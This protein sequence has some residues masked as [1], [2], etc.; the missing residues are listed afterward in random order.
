[1]R[2]GLGRIFVCSLL[3][4]GASVIAEDSSRE[5]VKFQT[6]DRCLACHNG[7]TT[8]A[9]K[10]VSIGLDWRASIMANSSRD[11]YW[12]ASIRR[13]TIDHP[14]SK[15]ALEDEC[16][17]CHMPIT[18]YE[19]KANRR[20]GEIFK[21]MPFNSNQ[22]DNAKAEDGVS[23]SVCHQISAQKLGTR[24]SF[25]GGFV[26]ELASKN[27]HAEYGPFDIERGHRRIMDTS[28]GGFLPTQAAHI[29][30]SALCGTCHT[31][32][33]EA[34][35]DGGKLIGQLPEQMPYREW[36]HSDYPTKSS[37]QACHMPQVNEAVP[38]TAVFGSPRQGLHQHTFLGGNFLMLNMLNRYRNELSVAALPSELIAA[39]EQT[40]HFLQSET[41]KVKIENVQLMGT[42]VK[43]SV[44]VQNLT[45]HKLPTAYPSRRAWLHVVVRDS[46]DHFV[47]E[48]GALNPDGSI[49]GN[50]NDADPARFAPHYREISEANQVEI[51]ESIMQDAEGHVTTGLIS[52]VGYLKDNRLLPAGFDKQT[53]E[54]DIAVIGDAAEDP[55]FRAGEDTMRYSLPLGNAQGPYH[56][57][58]ELW[59][60]PIGFRWAH[61]LNTYATAD[62]PRRFVS[63]YDFM[64]SGT[65]VILARDST[66]F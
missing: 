66:R 8:S 3:L 24:Q 13:E 33:T 59:Y 27:G 10:D 30:D 60:Q 16:S 31:L 32:Y 6:S 63:Y 41:A 57:E 19:A 15:S 14:E 35:G 43:F 65:A 39:A 20:Q 51:Y 64:S 22:K 49:K 4:C 42:E 34:R 48:S 26:V 50:Q 21:H 36:L 7:L 46:E 5:K 38:V 9:G 2:S 45:G 17:I 62:E 52:A 1:M 53:A 47:F 11:P 12:Q 40:I 54:K 58:A 56:V 37:C 44:L 55:T 28:T 25:V 18:R 23:C 29:R 61:N